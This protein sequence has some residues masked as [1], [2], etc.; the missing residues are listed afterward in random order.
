M[1]NYNGDDYCEDCAPTGSIE[2][3][4]AEQDAPVHCYNCLRPLD[5]TLTAAGVQY[6]LEYLRKA[7]DA[8][9]YPIYI[10]TYYEGSPHYAIRRD[11]AQ[12][13]ADYSLSDSD[14]KIVNYFLGATC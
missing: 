14:R 2:W 1:F 12:T 6:V 11:W 13:I 7:I 8:N 4:S 3:D 10:G 5:Y 9:V